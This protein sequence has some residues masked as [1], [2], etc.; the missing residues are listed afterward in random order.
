M[1]SG[2]ITEDRLDVSLRRILREKFEL[3]LF[4]NPYVDVDAVAELVGTDELRAAGTRRSA[5]R[6]PC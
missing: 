5:R 3:G 2:R 1:N 4:E 6:S